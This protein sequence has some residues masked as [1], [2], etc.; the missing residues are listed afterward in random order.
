MSSIYTSAE[1]AR[2]LERRYREFL[3][4]WPVPSEQ[5]WV[6]T[7]QGDTFV[8][9]CGPPDAPPVLLLHG[10]AGNTTTWLGD[11]ATWAQHF[12]VYAV[13][14]IG[15]PG[16][17]APSRPPLASD[18]HARWLDEVLAALAVE[19]A[20][21]VGVSLGGWLA[22]DYATRRPGRVDRLALLCP[23]GIGR[24]KW[25]KVIITVLLLKPWGRWGKRTTMTLLLGPS[26]LT[27]TPQGRPYLDYG[28]LIHRHFKPRWEK[29]P[30]F[31]DDTLQRLTMPMLVIVGGR[32]S[33]LD[34]T[35]TRRRLTQ[36]APHARVTLLPTAGHFPPAQTLPILDFLRAPEGA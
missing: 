20:A 18:A 2:I 17:S 36:T 21:F 34:S 6:P 1:G 15:E 8:V 22:V 23:G 14:M 16:L 12:R 29:V 32:D 9:A 28:V 24:Q 19:H 25:A 11:V 33:F 35:A 5:L 7:H 3:G 4:R 13:D 10:S 27:T 31:D 26:A 30:V